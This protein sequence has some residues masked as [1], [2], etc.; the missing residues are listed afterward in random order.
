MP[1][2]CLAKRQDFSQ[3]FLFIDSNALLFVYIEN[4]LSTESTTSTFYSTSLRI[5]SPPAFGW[6]FVPD[7]AGTS[8]RARKSPATCLSVPFQAGG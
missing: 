5:M 1:I 3:A 6:F 7:L 4:G 8:E 2:P